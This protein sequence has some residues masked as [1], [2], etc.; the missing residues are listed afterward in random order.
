MTSRHK[1]THAHKAQSYNIGRP[2]YPK[3]FFDYIYDELGLAKDSTIADMGAGTGK[4]T[5]GFLK[6]GSTVYALEPDKDMMQVLVNNLAGF[7]SCIPIESTAENTC[8]P[9]STVDLVF[10]GNSYHW[11]DSGIAV[12]EFKRVLRGNSRGFDVVIC[13]LGVGMPSSASPFQD[14]RCISKTFEF[15][16]HSRL[17]EFLHGHLSSS[18]APTPEDDNYEEYCETLKQTFDK[19]CVDGKVETRFVLH[20]EVGDVGGLVV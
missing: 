14:G 10:C 15:T 2:H 16:H 4:V 1:N 9:D 7:P 13:S 11:F 17:R 6:S 20:C 3:Q 19:Q 18:L 12:P 5:E 8:L